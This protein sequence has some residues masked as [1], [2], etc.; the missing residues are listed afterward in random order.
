MWFLNSATQNSSFSFNAL[1]RQS[2]VILT[3]RLMDHR[4]KNVHIDFLAYLIN[5]LRF[6]FFI[7]QIHALLYSHAK[8]LST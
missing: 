1:F 3:E 4:R 2:S 6:I 8:H 7:F 5:L